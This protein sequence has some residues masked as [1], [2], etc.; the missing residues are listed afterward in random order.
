MHP[1]GGGGGE[2]KSQINTE[3][4]NHFF[5][6]H[7]FSLTSQI[8]TFAS[9]PAD[10]IEKLLQQNEGD[11]RANPQAPPMR[12][13]KEDVENIRRQT[14]SAPAVLTELDMEALGFAPA[15]FGDLVKK[16]AAQKK[17]EDMDWGHMSSDQLPAQ[18]EKASLENDL[19]KAQQKQK[20]KQPLTPMP[21]PA[22]AD[23]IKG[24]GP[25]VKTTSTSTSTSPQT[26]TQPQPQSRWKNENISKQPRS[27]PPTCSDYSNPPVAPQYFGQDANMMPFPQMGP[28]GGPMGGVPMR[29]NPM[30]LAQM[31]QQMQQHAQ[32]MQMNGMFD[33]HMGMSHMGMGMPMF[34]NMGPYGGGQDAYGGRRGGGGGAA[35]R[36]PR[37][38]ATKVRPCEH[39]QWERISKKKHS[40]SLRCRVCRTC[41]KTRL[42]FFSKC[43]AF[44]AGE[45]EFGAKCPHPHIYSKAA[46]KHQMLKKL[47]AEGGAAEADDDEGSDE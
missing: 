22:A 21:E 16:N 24:D 7:F 39:N 42:E 25:R 37:M 34:P 33:P 41:W 18:L 12:F 27:V 35:G 26:Q 11:Q 31:Q 9:T 46:E 2:I 5:I 23:E 45:C 8:N 32:Q 44:Y 15:D 29:P 6:Q 4:T 3:R 1:L 40:I 38:E 47:D 14:C 28:W 43:T 13:S 17:V 20:Q 10:E 30:G 36:K 19:K